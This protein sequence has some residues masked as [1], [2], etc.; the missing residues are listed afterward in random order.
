MKIAP[1]FG[2]IGRCVEA[3]VGY[4]VPAGRVPPL[5]L[6][7]GQEAGDPRVPLVTTYLGDDGYVLEAIRADDVDGVVVAGFG[8]GHVSAPMAEAMWS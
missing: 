1:V 8:A 4:G 6:S 3:E 2:P 7:P 5:R